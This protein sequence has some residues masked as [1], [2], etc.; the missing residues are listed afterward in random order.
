MKAKLTSLLLLLLLFPMV[1]A[2]AAP[3][4]VSGRVTGP[5]GNP[6]LGVS[7]LVKGTTNVTTTN[8][9]GEFTI[10]ASEGQVI[11]FSYIGSATT[12][13]TVN[14]STMNVVLPEEANALDVKCE[15]KAL[16]YNVQA[17]NVNRDANSPAGKLAGVNISSGN[18]T[19]LYVIDGIPMVDVNTDSSP[20]AK[21]S[22][23]DINSVTVLP[24]PSATVLYGADAAGGAIII[25]TKNGPKTA[26]N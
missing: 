19:P 2:L 22:H 1:S 16:P 17:F 12:E 7:I 9:G 20:L 8:T 21:I 24:G 13:V 10:K 11:R 23:A 26:H 5:A 15:Q 4:T 18:Y 3:I 14:G 25:T 6:L